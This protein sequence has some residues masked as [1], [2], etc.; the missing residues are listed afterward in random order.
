MKE[1]NS[2]ED[3]IKAIKVSAPT[4]YFR[5]HAL[6]KPAAW[7]RDVFGPMPFYSVKA[8]SD[9][10][11]LGALW[12]NGIRAFDIASIV[13][14]RQIR[15][16]F[17]EAILGY[18]HTV[19]TS[20]AIAESYFE[21]GC[22]IFALDSHSEL[23]KILTATEYA[24]DLTLVV[25]VGIKNSSALVALD[26]KFGAGTQLSIDLVRTARPHA[27]K[28]G[29]SF[30]VGSQAMQP[31]SYVSALEH[32][33]AVIRDAGVHVEVLNVGGGF[34]ALY[35]GFA[36]PPS[37]SE[38]QFQIQDALARLGLDNMAVWCEPGRALVS[39]AESLLTRIEHVT[40]DAIFINDGI[41]GALFDAGEIGWRFPAR[42]FGADGALKAGAET[43][44]RIVY[45]PTCD[46][47]DKLH[48]R[49]YLPV[50]LAIGDFVEFGC[51]GAYGRAFSTR[52]NGFGTYECVQVRDDPWPNCY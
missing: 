18:L 30:H 5:P 12:R 36:E 26:D 51:L 40:D 28:I 10:A 14:A 45:G 2:P 38:Y 44:P 46:S 42:A 6:E 25:R 11:V 39:H 37:L 15:Q 17:P 7:F 49:V 23:D 27:A 20:E 21:Q 1:F 50:D 24:D 16:A 13:E 35:P 31:Q 9:L 19:K 47:A 22:R 52:F 33:G 4:I 32:C 43:R 41:Y 8:N 48:H 29:V 34:P 3:H